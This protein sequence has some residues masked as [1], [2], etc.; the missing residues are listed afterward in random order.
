M[1]SRGVALLKAMN[2]WDLVKQEKLE[3]PGKLFWKQAGRTNSQ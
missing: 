2:R 1:A 3:V